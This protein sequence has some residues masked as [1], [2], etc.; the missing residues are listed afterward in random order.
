MG[1]F[2]KIAVYVTSSHGDKIRLALAESG[3]GHIGKYD[4]CS[5]TTK[6]IGRF[7]PLK[8]AKPFKGREGQIKKIAE[9]R[10][11]TICPKSRLKKVL[12]A[13]KRAHPYDE[14]AVDI[15]PLLNNGQL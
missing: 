8:G 14:P 2:V 1:K 4:F 12:A 3:C 13:I 10:I 15:Y 9:E 7:R 11:E 6:G 5:F